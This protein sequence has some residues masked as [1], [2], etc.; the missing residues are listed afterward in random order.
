MLLLIFGTAHTSA[1]PFSTGKQ[2][3]AWVH[4]RCVLRFP[5][6]GR[7]RRIDWK[8]EEQCEKAALVIINS[9]KQTQTPTKQNSNKSQNS[10]ESSKSIAWASGSYRRAFQAQRVSQPCHSAAAPECSFSKVRLTTTSWRSCPKY[11]NAL[12]AALF[13]L[14][15]GVLL[16]ML[17]VWR[18]LSRGYVAV[19]FALL[20]ATKA[21]CRDSPSLYLF[22]GKPALVQILICG[23]AIE[24]NN[25][26]KGIAWWSEQSLKSLA[27][28]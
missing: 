12:R 20:C 7:L 27:C 21:L 8:E 19:G 22:I 11:P 28:Y 25:L 26:L 17:K 1:C 18:Q 6:P 3:N 2:W 9:S 15:C 10:T 16:L 14:S 13:L 23:V 5:C 24:D 4:Y